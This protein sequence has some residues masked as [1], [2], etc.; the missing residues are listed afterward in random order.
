MNSDQETL[1]SFAEG[2][3]AKPDTDLGNLPVTTTSLITMDPHKELVVL[4]I[5][6]RSTIDQVNI[7]EAHIVTLKERALKLQERIERFGSVN[8]F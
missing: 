4:R 1:S 6:N 7:I 2:T 3:V 5:D 8:G